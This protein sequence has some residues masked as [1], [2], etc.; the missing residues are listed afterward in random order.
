M[1]SSSRSPGGALCSSLPFCFFMRNYTEDWDKQPRL[2]RVEMKHEKL[3]GTDVVF[4]LFLFV[5]ARERSF[6]SLS[7]FLFLYILNCIYMFGFLLA[8]AWSYSSCESTEWDMS[9]IPT[10]QY[11]WLQDNADHFARP[12]QTPT[13]CYPR[14]AVWT[15]LTSLQR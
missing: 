4:G 8:A 6:C 7:R 11:G 5:F 9:A 3:R 2:R 12:S 14:A 10:C 15:E 1:W 13:H